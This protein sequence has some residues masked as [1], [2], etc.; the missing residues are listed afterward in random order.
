[1]RY[2]GDGFYLAEFP[3]SGGEHGGVERTI[4]EV[5]DGHVYTT[6][7]AAYTDSPLPIEETIYVPI[8]KLV[9]RPTTA[10]R[11]RPNLPPRSHGRRRMAV[12]KL[13]PRPMRYRVLREG[14]P[15]K[16]IERLN[17]QPSFHHERL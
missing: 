4:I 7:D 15:V 2:D 13:V 16:E 3:F 1:M 14:K 8:Q 11:S 9:M 17:N 6:N 12:P 5:H 10:H